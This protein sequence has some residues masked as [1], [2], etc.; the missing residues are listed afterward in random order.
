MVPNKN[1]DRSKR[2]KNLITIR[3]E[4]KKEMIAKFEDSV[5]VVKLNLFFFLP[6]FYV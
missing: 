3:M 6:I 1:T 4:V 2:K 5:F